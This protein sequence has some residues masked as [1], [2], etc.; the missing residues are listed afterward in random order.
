MLK[1]RLLPLED[2]DFGHV[3]DKNHPVSTLQQKREDCNSFVK[4]GSNWDKTS[5]D[6]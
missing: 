4:S 1:R 2:L 6:N 3:L 5:M